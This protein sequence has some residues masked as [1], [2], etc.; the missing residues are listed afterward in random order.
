ML[1]GTPTVTATVSDIHSGVDSNASRILINGSSVSTS[2]DQAT[3]TFTTSGVSW[4]EGSNSLE[5]RMEDMLGNA[6][7]PLLWSVTVD[8]K[9]PSGIVVINGD[10][11][12]TTNV[13]VTLTL[14]ASDVTSGLASLLISNEELTGYTEEPYVGIRELWP[15]TAIRGLRTV[16]VK[17]KDKAGNVSSPV[18]D[19]IALTLLSPATVITSGPA[20]FT[21]GPTATF[22]FMCPEQGCVFSYAFDNEE[23]SEWS[24]TQT[25][26]TSGLTF[27]NHY[28][29]VKAAKDVNDEPGIQLDEEDPSPAERTWVVGVAPPVFTIPEGPH[30]KIWRLE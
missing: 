26:A 6:Q 11:A 19:S 15:L 20:G 4:N 17:F 28:F 24:A 29:R 22:T 1:G 3:G 14:S 9:P 18:S 2:F 5:L 7:T 13:Y 8:T 16:F 30:I 10:A 23:W 27:G 25:A 21:P 12:M